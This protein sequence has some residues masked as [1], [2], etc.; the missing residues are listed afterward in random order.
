MANT[1]KRKSYFI[2]RKFQSRFIVTFLISVM[3]AL[4]IFSSGIVGYYWA[5]SMAGDNIFKEFITIDKQVFE[6]RQV[7][8]NGEF[9]TVRIPTTKTMRGIRR[10]EIV[11]PPILINN[12]VILVVISVIGI[13]YSH[14]LIGPVYRMTVDLKR[15]L[16]GDDNVRI[17]L[18]KKDKYQELADTINGLLDRLEEAER[19]Q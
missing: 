11:V 12:L 9:K 8:Q 10:W 3:I 17:R 4:L 15:R 19:K 6:T 14:R 16:T 7:E 18:R 2:D 5:S 1:N 13:F